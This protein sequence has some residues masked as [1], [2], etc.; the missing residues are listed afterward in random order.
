MNAHEATALFH[1]G[2]G[3]IA[4]LTFWIAALARKGSVPHR[5]AG[6]VYL[7]AMLGLLVPAIP[8]SAAVFQKS[9]AF[10]SFLFYLVLITVSALWQGW[11]AVR[12]KRDFS[13]YA[14]PGL[15][16]LAWI[17]IAAG[18]AVLA[19][20][21]TL[22]QPIF[23]GFSLIGLLGGPGMLKLIRTGPAH[24]RWWMEQHL[25]AMLGCGVATHIAFLSLGLPR[26]LPSLSGQT[27]QLIAWM[28]PLALSLLARAWLGRKYLP[29]RPSNHGSSPHTSP[30]RDQ[31]SP[32]PR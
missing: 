6:R 31:P 5:Y 11:F 16:N 17:N 3:T 7:V 15:R 10:G 24:P 29:R 4:L 27:L 2:L 32:L 23:I 9:V 25:G 22:K 30:S 28:G 18:A 26:L 13:R 12:H 8:L 14:G 1:A 19:L 21:I 20:G